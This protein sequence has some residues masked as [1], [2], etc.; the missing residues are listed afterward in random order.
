MQRVMRNSFSFCKGKPKNLNEN[1]EQQQKNSESQLPDGHMDVLGSHEVLVRIPRAVVHL[2]DGSEEI[3]ELGSGEFTLI[4]LL[5]GDTGLAVLAKVGDDLSWPIT[6][7]EPTVKVDSCHYLFSVRPPNEEEEISDSVK[8]GRASG[9]EMLNY[10]VTFEGEE[11]LDMLDKC[12]EHHACF[13]FP[14]DG[15]KLPSD[16][17]NSEGAYWADLAPNVEDYNS[18]LAKAIASGSGQIIKGLFQC[19]NAYSSQVQ[20]GGDFVTS[21]T[22]TKSKPSEVRAKKGP[23]IN[24]RTKRNIK[25]VKKLSKMTEKMSDNVLKGVITV[26]GAVTGP[27]IMSQAGKKFFSML[28]G[29]VLLASLDAINKVMEAV[30]VAAKDALSATSDMTSEIISHRFGEDAGEVTQEV[31]EVAGYALGTAINIVKIRKAINPVTNG[32]VSTSV[33]KNSFKQV[34]E[35]IK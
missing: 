27:V 5:Q 32:N 18:M 11:G 14:K 17:A 9:T 31:F 16:R 13:S 28:P 7:D 3:V 2:V 22:K 4:R 15:G 1:Y 6:K 25:R 21:K 24:P 29:E 34:N 20:K 12:L 23:E 30:E 35:G 8:S 10:G 33:I 26:S 19:S